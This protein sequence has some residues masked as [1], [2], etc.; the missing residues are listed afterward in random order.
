MLTLIS[1][2]RIGRLDLDTE[3]IEVLDSANINGL[4]DIEIDPF[5][6]FIYWSESGSGSIKRANF[7]GTLVETLATGLSSPSGIAIL[8][9]GTGVVV[10]FD[11][12]PQIT[13][14]ETGLTVPIS[15]VLK[16]SDSLPTT[17]AVTVE[18][19]DAGTG[20]AMAGEDYTEFSPVSVQFPT[21]SIS[22][23][24][25]TFQLEIVD[26]EVI[27]VDETINLH[28][29]NL[30][31]KAIFGPDQSLQ[32]IITD[33]AQQT[34]IEFQ[35][36]TSMT[37]PESSHPHTVALTL[38]TPSGDPV[39]EAISVDVL[40]S[41][42][43]SATVGIDYLQFSPTTVVFP[44]GSNNGAVQNFNFSIL[45]DNDIEGEETINLHLGNVQDFGKLGDQQTHEVIIKDD[46]L[47]KVSFQ[48]VTSVTIDES[49]VNHSIPI[50]LSIPD[51]G[52]MEAEIAVRIIDAGTGSATVNSDYSDSPAD[53][54]TFPPG[55]SNGLIQFFSLPILD[56]NVAEGDETVE[57]EL[58]LVQGPVELEDPSIHRVVITDDE[59]ELNL[60]EGWN[61][62]STPIIPDNDVVDSI[63]ETME[64][65]DSNSFMP[66]WFWVKGNYMNASR[67]N[68]GIG[69]WISS[70][71][72]IST[73]ISGAI[74]DS[75]EIELKKGWN[76]IGVIGVHKIP[77]SNL[78]DIGMRIWTW[79]RIT[80][81]NNLLEQESDFLEPGTGYW[82]YSSE[83]ILLQFDQF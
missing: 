18:I 16:T 55:S 34:S 39:S 41:G 60:D 10:E 31:G 71:Q 73:V 1:L 83:S 35:S 28:L 7:D 45:E 80:Q 59:F 52:S 23:N 48:D 77:L 8:P 43:G 12:G 53:S 54:L 67:I 24:Q 19:I 27:E 3:D 11:I 51:Q 15:L 65:E 37:A 63:F 5:T 22:G 58:S 82:I 61:L 42:S 69:Y 72:K 21:E 81:K 78:S 66:V 79:D 32:I 25:K 76:L 6:G 44:A 20:T 74:P 56:D 4:Q 9:E 33:P 29:N 36:S 47:A 49:P 38:S 13:I 70:T 30:Q 26:D 64:S 62:I 17:E 68:C 75:E 2:D 14:D 40:D 46:D 50:Q 57:F